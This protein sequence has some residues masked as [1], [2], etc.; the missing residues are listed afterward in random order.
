MIGQYVYQDGYGEGVSY[1][2]F[3][4]DKIVHIDDDHITL[5]NAKVELKGDKWYPSNELGDKIY[6]IRIVYSKKGTKAKKDKD[7]LYNKAIQDLNLKIYQD[8][9]FEE[10]TYPRY[11]TNDGFCLYGY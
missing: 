9:M 1:N 10:L 11:K 4:F 8:G 5:I 6:K 3:T 2:S 7:K